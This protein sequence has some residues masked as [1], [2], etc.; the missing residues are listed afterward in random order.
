MLNSFYAN[1][2]K[3]YFTYISKHNSDCGKQV[4]LFMTSKE[5]TMALSCSKRTISIIKWNNFQILWWFVLSDLTSF[6][7]NRK[8]S[9]SLKK[10]VKIKTL[11]FYKGLI[12]PSE[13]TKILE[14]NQN[15]ISV[16]APIIT[17]ADL[18]CIIEKTDGCKNNPEN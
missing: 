10:Y 17:F 18:Q 12:M 5:K 7:R 1:K 16:K 9:N 14:F 15:Q 4:T 8:N 2:E 3:I 6:F 13:D 11:W